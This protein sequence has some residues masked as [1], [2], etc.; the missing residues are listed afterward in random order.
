MEGFQ[1]RFPWH[2]DGSIK[3]RIRN[4]TGMDALINTMKQS[5]IW[6]DRTKCL[7]V[8]FRGEMSL[9]ERLLQGLET[10]IPVQ[11]REMDGGK[12]RVAIHHVF[13]S[14]TCTW[15]VERMIS[16]NRMCCRST[17]PFSLSQAKRIYS[18]NPRLSSKPALLQMASTPSLCCPWL[19][20]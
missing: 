11:K 6:L 2:V 18:S 12:E 19:P 17:R 15:L 5:E 3:A 7:F 4:D 20:R 13:T 16:L 9:I 10:F 1:V 14:S 8:L